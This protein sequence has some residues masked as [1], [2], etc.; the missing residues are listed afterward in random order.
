MASDDN[1]LERHL[2][3]AAAH[4][5]R[6]RI[7]STIEIDEAIDEMEMLFP[8]EAVLNAPMGCAHVCV[9]TSSAPASL[10]DERIREHRSE[11]EHLPDF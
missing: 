10:I 9:Y 7:V 1:V 8:H 6:V 3:H 2:A 4:A 5:S 11:V